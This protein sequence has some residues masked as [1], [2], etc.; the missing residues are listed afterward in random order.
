MT[1]PAIT[2]VHNQRV[3]NAIRLRDHRHRAKQGRFFIDGA[4][5]LLQA[6]RGGVQFLELFICPELCRSA[7]S[8]EVLERV[9]E[10]QAD[11]WE[12][13]PEVFEKLAYGDRLEGVLAIAETSYPALAELALPEGSLIAVLEGLEKPGNVGAVLRSADGAGVGAVVAA[14]PRTDL[15]NP[16]CIRASLGTI[17]TQRVVQATAAETLAWLRGRGSKIFV[18][19]LDAQH[20]YSDVDF[21]G[22]AAIVLGS[23]AAGLSAEWHSADV[24]P[25]KLPMRGTA[26]SLNVSAAA[27]V[28]FYEALRQ[29]EQSA[30]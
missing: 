7:E 16:N 19:R 30:L 4:R 14:D 1:R 8:R 17:F 20:L 26:D 22:D 18:A 25:I 5:E 12:L 10:L 24:T 6:M 29:R 11:V 15:Y 13:V 27:A 3:K 23:E 28:L 21:R 9:R 2:S